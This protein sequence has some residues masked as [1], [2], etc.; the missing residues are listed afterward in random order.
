M[1]SYAD[2]GAE[3]QLRPRN[4][5]ES[6]TASLQGTHE[7]RRE[8]MLQGARESADRAAANKHRMNTQRQIGMSG[9]GNGLFLTHTTLNR[10]Q[11]IEEIYKA[12]RE[13]ILEN[14]RRYKE[15]QANPTGPE[16]AAIAEFAQS[17]REKEQANGSKPRWSLKQ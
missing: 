11:Y 5:L 4:W 10:D 6:F 8:R 1:S 7:E 16:A 3:Q 12:N 2:S 14:N 13:K 15:G 9:T 17:Q